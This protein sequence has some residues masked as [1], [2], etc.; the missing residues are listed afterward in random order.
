MR[1]LLN[2]KF[3][4]LWVISLFSG[5]I[6]AP[7]SQLP[8][9]VDKVLEYPPIFTAILRAMMLSLGGVFALL[10][11]A[12]SDSLGRKKTFLLGLTGA[13]TSGL[14]FIFHSPLILLLIS[15]YAGFAF[16]MRTPAGQS[17]LM[18]SVPQSSLGLG[19]AVYFQ[20]LTLGAAVG[21]F[22]GGPLLE[23]HGFRI[24]GIG[25][26]GL[27]VIIVFFA[28]LVLPELSR[29]SLT[30]R[31]SI[32]SVLAGYAQMVRR[33][34][35]KIL[36]GLR[37]LPTYYWGTVTL[38]IP[39]LISRYTDTKIWPSYYSGLSL[40]I[41]SLFQIM[42][43]K[44]CDIV[45]RRKPVIIAT[46]FITLSAAMT[47]VFAHSVLGLF[48]FGI[49]GAASAW[50]LSTTMPSLINDLTG[51]KDKGRGVGVT[52]LAWSAGM[53]SGNLVAGKIVDFNVRLPF[54]IATA[55][56]IIAVVLA[57]AL[58]WHPHAKVEA[59]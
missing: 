58:F 27:M 23:I 3:L 5:L 24:V 18:D 53:L 13:L 12:L 21:N 55:G 28:V 7:L 56:C 46:I 35:M 59:T 57:F 15:I 29:Q 47:G 26:T 25:I 17:Y 38:L 51:E 2:R 6:A 32:M 48:I 44:L 37:Y 41:A 9:Y 33:R 34:E 8:V 14:L 54:Y 52:H 22:I 50:S 49:M 19:T 10:G 39:L 20:G 42:T 30:Q 43:G 11:G 16:G 36:L 4:L 1:E 40:L 45:G 31:E